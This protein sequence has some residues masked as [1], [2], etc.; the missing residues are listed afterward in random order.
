MSRPGF[1]HSHFLS[2]PLEVYR[3]QTQFH[4]VSNYYTSPQIYCTGSLQF[5]IWKIVCRP[6]YCSRWRCSKGIPTSSRYV[7]LHIKIGWRKVNICRFGSGKWF[8]SCTFAQ[9]AE[10]WKKHGKVAHLLEKSV[11]SMI[12]LLHPVFYWPMIMIGPAGLQL[13][14]PTIC[15]PSF[16]LITGVAKK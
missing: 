4:T 12:W 3:F 5:F 15:S 7:T 14:A 1:P 8:F 9:F 13:V 2:M 6:F 11:I 16:S 10:A